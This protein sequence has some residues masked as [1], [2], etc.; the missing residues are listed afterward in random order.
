MKRRRRTKKIV[1]GVTGSIAAYKAV[2]LLRALQNEGADVRVLMTRAATELSPAPPRRT[3]L[4]CFRSS[5]VTSLSALTG[6][7]PKIMG[8]RLVPLKVANFSAAP[9]STALASNEPRV[10]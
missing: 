8:R 4:K 5:S 1:L 2:E 10:P 9:R 7:R 3:R 6:T